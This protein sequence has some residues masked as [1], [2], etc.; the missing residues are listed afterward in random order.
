MGNLP[1]VSIG[2]PVYNGEKYIRF[3]L[4]S[5]LCQDYLNTEVII[6]DN[7]STDNTQEICL[8]YMTLDKRVRYLR[9]ESNVGA[10]NNFKRVFSLS[11]GKYFMWAACD[12]LWVPSFISSLYEILTSNPKAVLAMSRVGNCD[13]AGIS[14]N[15]VRPEVLDTQGMN[16]FKRIIYVI[17]AFSGEYVYGLF[18]REILSMIIS[19]AQFD[20]YSGSDPVVLLQKTHNIIFKAASMGDIVTSP[21]A[22][23]HKRGGTSGL[24]DSTGKTI[25]FVRWFYLFL[26][27]LKNSILCFDLPRLNMVQSMQLIHLIGS[28]SR[29]VV[30]AYYKSPSL[31]LLFRGRRAR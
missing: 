22:L 6:T 1:L 3:A 9:N 13:A 10:F 18:K 21:V 29:K 25:N 24:G 26:F 23:F 15:W 30:R 27:Y 31:N 28:G 8:E 17:S 4:N 7:A 5:L 19:S 16:Y 14:T 11:H 20:D 2:M 12:D